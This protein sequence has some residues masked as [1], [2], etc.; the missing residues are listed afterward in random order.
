[1]INLLQLSSK[2]LLIIM[3]IQSSSVKKNTQEM[4]H[5]LVL[6]YLHH[7]MLIL[8]LVYGQNSD[9]CVTKD[10]QYFY[11]ILLDTFKTMTCCVLL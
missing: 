6:A 3:A 11:L 9:K 8:F 4:L 10:F 2:G 5:N 7:V 1:M